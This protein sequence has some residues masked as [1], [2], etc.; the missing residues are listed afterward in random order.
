VID[1]WFFSDSLTDKRRKPSPLMMLEAVAKYN[2]DLEKSIMIGDK[3]SDLIELT[4]P[5]YLLIRGNYPL[6]DCP[7]D[8][9][10]FENLPELSLYLSQKYN[11]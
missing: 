7:K 11:V 4:G 1:D 8:V 2:I 10:I 6:L 9:K 3:L 5:E